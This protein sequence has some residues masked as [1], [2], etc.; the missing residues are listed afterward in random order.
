MDAAFF[1]R[2][3]FDWHCAVQ[4]MVEGVNQAEMMQCASCGRTLAP[5]RAQRD[6]LERELKKISAATF[7]F[8]RAALRVFTSEVR[9]AGAHGRY[10]RP[11]FRHPG[12]R[13]PSWDAPH[14][15]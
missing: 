4:C 3:F 5:D 7:S 1:I 12:R 8:K 9:G 6:L 10:S 11:C 13:D 14:S 2:Y 15:Q